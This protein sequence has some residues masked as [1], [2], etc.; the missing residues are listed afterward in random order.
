MD[1]NN[2]PDFEKFMVCSQGINSIINKIV[3]ENVANTDTNTKDD[4]ELNN[5][6]I[7]VDCMNKELGDESETRLKTI[8]GAAKIITNGN[9]NREDPVRIAA[10]VDDAFT[11]SKLTYLVSMGLMTIEDSLNAL[12]DRALNRCFVFLENIIDSGVIKD[13]IIDRIINLTA[14]IPEF[15][16][17]IV[18]QLES[19]R[20]IFF[21]ILSG[22]DNKIKESCKKVIGKLSEVARKSLSYIRQRI[23]SWAVSVES[24][25]KKQ[26]QIV[27]S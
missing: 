27:N 5:K 20:E 23:E 1:I 24:Y 22:F 18:P 8:L 26:K 7:I 11:K 6:D 10:S 2:V 13:F 21:V 15:G 14:L 17:I 9:T 4:I 16:P 3:T 19:N 25:I 12:V